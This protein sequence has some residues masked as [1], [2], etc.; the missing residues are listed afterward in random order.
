MN[1]SKHACPHAFNDMHKTQAH[2]PQFKNEQ[3]NI[4]RA[5]KQQPARQTH[6]HTQT[7]TKTHTMTHT[8]ALTQANTRRSSRASICTTKR[9]TPSRN[10]HRP[11]SKHD[12]QHLVP[13]CDQGIDQ[14]RSFGNASFPSLSV[15]L[16]LSPSLILAQGS[17]KLSL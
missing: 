4:Q 8:L 14:A 6:T 11:I 1:T 7:H 15:S 16:P 5:T 17:L 12:N 9:A 13:A 2:S 3:A 10:H